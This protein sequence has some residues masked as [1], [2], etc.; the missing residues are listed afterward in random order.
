M[1]ASAT[2][3]GSDFENPPY[4][5]FEWSLL[6]KGLRGGM[7]RSDRV[8][9]LLRHMLQSVRSKR[10]HRTALLWAQVQRLP[11]PIYSIPRIHRRKPPLF[12]RGSGI[13]SLLRRMLQSARSKSATKRSPSRKRSV[14]GKAPTPQG[15]KCGPARCAGV[16][17]AGSDVKLIPVYIGKMVLHLERLERRKGADSQEGK[18]ER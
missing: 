3:A 18:K 10:P 7:S 15:F 11:D 16:T 8:V 14:G 12:Q 9:S 2:S 1:G 13:V 17:S 6:S 5:S 4:I